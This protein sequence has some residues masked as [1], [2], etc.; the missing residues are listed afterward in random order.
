M[1]NLLPYA[2]REEKALGEGLVSCHVLPLDVDLLETGR[3]CARLQLQRA[4]GA[5][6]PFSGA[7][8]LH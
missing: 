5:N 2:G 7:R 4:A 6:N 1:V 3:L 8:L